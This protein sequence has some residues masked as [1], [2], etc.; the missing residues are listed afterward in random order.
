MF[1]CTLM[2]AF[3]GSAEEPQPGT[4]TLQNEPVR[5][6]T[7]ELDGAATETISIQKDEAQVLAERH[8]RQKGMDLSQHRLA[9]VRLVSGSPWMRRQHWILTWE[10][11]TPSDGG[12]VFVLVGM[13]KQVKVGRGL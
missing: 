5:K 1:I 2:A 9:R 7:V 13:D 6:T 3:T 8:L 11:R 10:L 12:Q 4:A